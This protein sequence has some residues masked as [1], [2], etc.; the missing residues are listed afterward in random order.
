MISFDAIID[1]Y[2]FD[3]DYIGS[4]T[5]LCSRYRSHKVPDKIQ[6]AKRLNVMYYLPMK[7][8]FY[9]YEIKLIKALKPLY[10]YQHK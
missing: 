8:G 5:M 10:N 2:D 7:K 9:D 6:S 4:T 3:I 1:G